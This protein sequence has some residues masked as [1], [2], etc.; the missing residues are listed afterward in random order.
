MVCK[1]Y[2]HQLTCLLDAIGKFIITPAGMGI[3][4]RM[5]MNGTYNGGI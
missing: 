5:I 1:V 3:T 2:A 4:T